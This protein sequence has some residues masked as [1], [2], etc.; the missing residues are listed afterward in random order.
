MQHGSPRVVV[1]D[2][3]REMGDVRKFQ[4]EVIGWKIRITN[5]PHPVRLPEHEFERPAWRSV[6]FID[7]AL[8]LILTGGCLLP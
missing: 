4:E 6:D 2:V 8:V 5:V 3:K 1:A 7:T